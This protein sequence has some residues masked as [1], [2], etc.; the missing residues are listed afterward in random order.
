MRTQEIACALACLAIAARELVEALEG[1]ADALMLA[2][3]E[4]QR[5]KQD[6]TAAIRR[7]MTETP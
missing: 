5:A 4:A 6:A 1:L 7:A 3:P 2:S